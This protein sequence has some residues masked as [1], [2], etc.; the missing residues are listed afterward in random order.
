MGVLSC[1]LRLTNRHFHRYGIDGFWQRD[2]P[3]P[4]PIAFEGVAAPMGAVAV[5][6]V[7]LLFG[8]GVFLNL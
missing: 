1:L 3:S 6:A 5:E 8:A 7:V 4:S 2:E